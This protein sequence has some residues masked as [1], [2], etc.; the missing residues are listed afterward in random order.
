MHFFHELIIHTEL[1]NLKMQRYLLD[2][3]SFM[4]IDTYTDIDMYFV[5]ILN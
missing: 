5:G 3:Y 4:G 1:E 2:L